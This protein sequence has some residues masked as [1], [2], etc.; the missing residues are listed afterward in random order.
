[1]WTRMPPRKHR[2]RSGPIY[3]FLQANGQDTITERLNDGGLQTVLAAEIGVSRQGLS[4]WIDRNVP[5]SERNRLCAYCGKPLEPNKAWAALYHPECY[6]LE[7]IRRVATRSDIAQWR[8]R[9]SLRHFE[10]LALAEYERRG[11]AVEWTPYYAPFVFIVNGLYVAVRGSTLSATRQL[12]YWL[13]RPWDRR[14]R[15]GYENLPSRCDIIHCIGEDKGECV[16]LIL[17]AE[18]AGKRYA[19]SLRP[20]EYCTGRKPNRNLKYQDR[21]RLFEATGAAQLAMEEMDA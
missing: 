15:L 3:H 17:T 1:M 6:H 20:P 7:I 11:Y 12:F 9:K 5:L 19:L 13:L 8:V 4:D 2:N 14:N 16:H 18:E 21:W 10:A